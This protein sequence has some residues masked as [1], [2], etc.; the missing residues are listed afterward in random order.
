MNGQICCHNI[1]CLL[2]SDFLKF[3]KKLHTLKFAL[4]AYGYILTFNS[5]SVFLMSFLGITSPFVAF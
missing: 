3:S 4:F 1:N 2:C 5:S